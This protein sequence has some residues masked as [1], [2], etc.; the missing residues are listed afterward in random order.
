[1]GLLQGRNLRSS[2][3]RKRQLCNLGTMQNVWMSNQ[4][5]SCL[6]AN[7]CANCS[8][9]DMPLPS[10]VDPGE[11][12][13]RIIHNLTLSHQEN[14]LA[15]QVYTAEEIEINQDVWSPI[16]TYIEECFSR[17]CMG[18]LD[19]EAYLREICLAMQAKLEDL[20]ATH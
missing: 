20:C 6:S 17:F 5:V 2:Y 9:T 19:I 18:D 1:M 3:L 16:S 7:G 4:G 10:T 11:G 15:A 8:G 13:W 12:A 14:V